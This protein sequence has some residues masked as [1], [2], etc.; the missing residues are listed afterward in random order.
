MDYDVLVAGAGPV[1]LT[2]AGQL[3]RQGLRCLA[4]DRAATRTDKSKALVIWP[5]TLELLRLAGLVEPFTA[6]GLAVRTG[7]LFGGSRP[8]ATLDFSRSG[9]AFAATLLI[10]QSDTERLL[11]ADV[12]AGSAELR[13]GTALVR[14]RD[15]G[16][17]VRCALR[18]AD[19]REEEVTAGWLVGCDGAHSTV[20]HGLGLVFAGAP[21]NNDWFLAD[22]RVDGPLPHDEVRIHLHADGV[23]AFFPIPPDRFR[24]IGDLGRSRGASPP[25]PSLADVQ[26]LLDRRGPGGLTARD[27]VWLAGFRINE[28]QVPTYR[29]GRVLLAGDAAHIHSP[30][31][32]QGMNTGMQDAFNLAW[33]LALVHRG[34]A[35]PELLESY[36]AERHRVGAMIVRGTS[37]VTRMATLRHPLAQRLRDFVVPHLT[38]LAPV[39]NAVI[40]MLTETAIHYRGSRIVRDGRAQVGRGMLRAGDRLPD[41]ALGGAPLHDRLRVDRHTVLLPTAEYGAAA[42]AAFPGLVTAIEIGDVLRDGLGAGNAAVVRPDGYLGY[43]G[44]PERMAGFLDTYLLRAG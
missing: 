29:V 41:V 18:T 30:A 28:R 32:G 43:A 6:A 21:D 34:R 15:D 7:R 3:S 16:A 10:P 2:L 9:S 40:G 5:R 1:G 31:G 20:R 35:R 12:A 24:I 22:V 37:L 36:Q 19:G 27:P 23:M 33:K 13:R 25:E 38:R 26:A 44:P 39:Q 8:L 17:R 4:V 42:E 11:E 14:F